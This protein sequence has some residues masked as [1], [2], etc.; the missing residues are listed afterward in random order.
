MVLQVLPTPDLTTFLRRSYDQ[1]AREIPS[2]SG[3]CFLCNYSVAMFIHSCHSPTVE[4]PVQQ[5]LYQSPDPVGT[6]DNLYENIYQDPT[7]VSLLCV[8]KDGSHLDT[9]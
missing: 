9:H 1:T 6:A 8:S 3:K 2:A 5:D 7:E 4:S